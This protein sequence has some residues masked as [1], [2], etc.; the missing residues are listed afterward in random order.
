MDI[1]INLHKSSECEV[2]SSCKDFVDTA[3]TSSGAGAAAFTVFL[4]LVLFVLCLTAIISLAEEYES[5]F[6]PTEEDKSNHHLL[7][8]FLIPTVTVA[9]SVMPP[10]AVALAFVEGG[11]FTGALHFNGAFM[12]PFLYGLFPSY[13]TKA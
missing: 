8:Q 6:S 10:V 12:I 7:N 11:D 9:D 1:A 2:L 3:P 4:V 13:Y 5:L